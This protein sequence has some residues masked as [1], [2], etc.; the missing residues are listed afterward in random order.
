[1]QTT[2]IIAE[3]CRPR[4]QPNYHACYKIFHNRRCVNAYHKTSFNKIMQTTPIVFP[5]LKNILCVNKIGQEKKLETT[6]QNSCNI[7]KLEEKKNLEV[8]FLFS[9]K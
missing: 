2:A 1:M 6:N 7:S 8:T 9:K 4:K 5:L 3:V